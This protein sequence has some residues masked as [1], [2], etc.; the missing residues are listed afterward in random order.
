MQLSSSGPKHC[1]FDFEFLGNSSGEPYLL[2]TNIFVDG[3]GGREIQLRLWFDPTADYHYYNFQWNDNVVVFFIDSTPIRMFG[4]YE[5]LNTPQN[6]TLFQYPKS[7]PMSLYLSIWD[8]SSWATQGGK[9]KL[10]WA[11]APFT[12]HYKNFRLNGCQAKQND[13]ASIAACQKSTFAKPGVRIDGSRR[14]KLR[15]VRDNFV[16]YNYC[17]DT[18]RYPVLPPECKYNVL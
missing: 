11:S 6:P 16:H 8:G 18:A 2:H 3:V 17:T 12:A 13:Q 1:E 7:C 5:S 4:N 9:V 14:R 10:N 15:W